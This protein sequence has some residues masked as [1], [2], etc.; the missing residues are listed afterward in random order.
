[1]RALF[2]GTK[3]PICAIKHDQGN[4]AQE[5]G[6]STHIW[7]GN[8]ADDLV[9]IHDAIIWY[10]TLL[11]ES[12][13]HHRM[14]AI[15]DFQNGYLLKVPGERNWKELPHQQNW[16]KHRVWRLLGRSQALP[17]CGREREL[18]ISLKSRFSISRIRSSAFNTRASYSF[19]SGVI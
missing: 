17:E 15:D 14:P 10:K 4:L 3:E 6:F 11:V 12:R 5:C 19:I 16:R 18:Q 9:L 13:F 7:S 1:M 8:D 2:A